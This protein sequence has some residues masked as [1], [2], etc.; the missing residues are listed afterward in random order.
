MFV[1][2][3]FGRSWLKVES[4]VKSLAWGEDGEVPATLYLQREEPSGR[5]VLLSSPSLFLEQMELTSVLDDIDEFEVK[6]EFKFATTRSKGGKEMELLVSVR[7]GPFLKAAFPS[8]L[9]KR[10][11]HV[12][13]ISAD[14]Q[15]R[16]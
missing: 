2:Q 6:G 8:L 15:V 10:H 16:S 7:K 9:E 14:G 11:F 4:H 13:D 3:D 1:S 12:A 5:S